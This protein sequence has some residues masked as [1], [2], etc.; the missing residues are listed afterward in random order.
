MRD[1]LDR[2]SIDAADSGATADANASDLIRFES[3]VYYAPT[4]RPGEPFARSNLERR[5][6]SE[7]LCHRALGTDAERADELCG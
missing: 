3:V 1:E 7:W 6:A 5:L 4:R 2:S